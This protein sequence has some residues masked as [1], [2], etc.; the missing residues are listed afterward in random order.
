[1]SPLEFMERLAALLPRPR[2]HLIRFHGVLAPNAKLRCE[3]IPSLA[4]HATEHSSD[5]AQGASARMS[6]ARLFKR[7]RSNGV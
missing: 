7:S 2:L 4:E 5:H 6:W 3:I 1:M